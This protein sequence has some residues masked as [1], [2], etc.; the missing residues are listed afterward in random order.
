MYDEDNSEAEDRYDTIGSTRAGFT[1]TTIGGIAFTEDVL[2][3][4]YTERIRKTDNGTP[5]DVTRLISARMA[6]SFERGCI[7][8]N[9]IKDIKQIDPAFTKE[10]IEMLEN[11][12][13]REIIFDKDC[14]ET[15]PER[16]VKFKRVNRPSNVVGK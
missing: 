8:E 11:A 4:V 5:V 12:R 2:F 14:P 1:D 3:V 16:A 9:M 7:M 13:K 6:T 15:T 10:E